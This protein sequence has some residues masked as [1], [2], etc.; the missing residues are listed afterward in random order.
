MKVIR[1]LQE[2]ELTNAIWRPFWGLYKKERW[3]SSRSIRQSR[4]RIKLCVINLINII[5]PCLLFAC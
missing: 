4:N 5:Y 2:L 3:R 1:K